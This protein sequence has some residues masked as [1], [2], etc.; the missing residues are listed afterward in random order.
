MVWCVGTST[1]AVKRVQERIGAIVDGVALADVAEPWGFSIWNAES[2]VV[3]GIDHRE[4]RAVR[5]PQF[6]V[7]EWGELSPDGAAAIIDREPMAASLL[8]AHWNGAIRAHVLAEPAVTPFGTWR[9][10]SLAHRCL[11][12]VPAI[13]TVAQRQLAELFDKVQS[14]DSLDTPSFYAKTEVLSRTAAITRCPELVISA[15]S[16]PASLGVIRRPPTR[17]QQ[18]R[19]HE[20][21]R[22]VAAIEADSPLAARARQ[23]MLERIDA[24]LGEA[25]R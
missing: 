5:L 10:R 13:A 15:L 23:L 21:R 3:H 4:D 12:H 17:E 22:V 9:Y 11:D 14:R 25:G 18:R 16:L 6:R 2:M 7:G 24:R 19:Q 20:K 1:A 8:I